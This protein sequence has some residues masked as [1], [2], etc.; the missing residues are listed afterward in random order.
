MMCVLSFFLT[1]VLDVCCIIVFY[2]I[3]FIFDSASGR[4]I[5]I[6]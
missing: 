2:F 3:D 5:K 6:D 4:I 1:C